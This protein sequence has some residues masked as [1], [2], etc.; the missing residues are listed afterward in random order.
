MIGENELDLR[1]AAF[2][3]GE[4]S[5]EECA[6]FERELEHNPELAENVA[7]IAAND[8]MLRQAMAIEQGDASDQAFLARIG[9]SDPQ[10]PE[11]GGAIEP[12]APAN[13]NPPFW[14]RWELR[15]G[16][17]LAASLAL[18]VTVTLQGGGAPGLGDALDATPSGQLAALDSGAAVTPVLSFAAADGRFCREFAFQA[19]GKASGKASSGLACRSSGGWTVEA[20][21]DDAVEIPDSGEIALAGG[22]GPQDLDSA[23]ARLGAGDPIPLDRER[24]IIAKGWAQ[25]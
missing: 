2:L 13:D 10:Q 8:A 5:G 21:S 17:A 25:K 12:P 18:I 1:I 23:Y 4:M 14:K 19:S 9:L 3:D 16:A 6:A 20:W 15:A 7:R 11:T 22:E 24:E